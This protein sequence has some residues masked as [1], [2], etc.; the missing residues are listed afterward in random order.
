MDK[1]IINVANKHKTEFTFFLNN[2]FPHLM[3][4]EGGGKLHNV[5]GDSGGWTK[6]GIA[7]NYNKQHF[8]SFEDFKNTT[9]EEAAALAFSKYYLPLNPAYL[10][11]N[12]KLYMADMAYNLGTGRTIKYMQQC[13]KTTADGIIGKN[14]RAKMSNLTLSCIHLKRVNWYTYLANHRGKSKFIKGWMRRATDSYSK[15]KDC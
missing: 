3:L 1:N 14:T 4:W 7:Y 5:A 9:E 2:I 8:S 12:T 10:P 15:S 11:C 13:I 6:W